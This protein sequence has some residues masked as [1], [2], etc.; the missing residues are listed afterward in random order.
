MKEELN[1]KVIRL[2]SKDIH[3]NKFILYSIPS[4]IILASV[5]HFLFDLLNKIS[6]FAIFLP[7]NESIFEH[8]KLCLYPTLLVWFLGYLFINK[9]TNI[10]TSKWVI[11][12]TFSIFINIF[13]VLSLFYIG[14]SGFNIHST[15]YD[16][17]TLIIGTI[18]GQ[19][20]SLHVYNNI[21]SNNKNVAY[22]YILILLLILVMGFFTFNPPK[23][24]IFF[25]KVSQSY[26][27]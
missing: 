13:I 16:I 4:I 15:I 6:F 18:I 23:L 20:L 26:G 27:L 21:S 5:F 2:K 11:S 22:A 24:P 17:S 3:L 1:Y 8:L 14:S 25:D 9:K 10:D 7:V 12:L 19:I